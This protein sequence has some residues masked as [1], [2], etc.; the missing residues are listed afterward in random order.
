MGH[1]D[2]ATHVL[3]QGN[4]AFF[5]PRTDR[6]WFS[7]ADCN[8]VRQYIPPYPGSDRFAIRFVNARDSIFSVFCDDLVKDFTSFTVEDSGVARIVVLE[9]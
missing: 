9:D 3:F 6:Q 2:R 1:N 4:E 5:Q 8:N 7:V